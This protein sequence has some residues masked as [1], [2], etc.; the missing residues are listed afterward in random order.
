MLSKMVILVQKS[1]IYS[2]TFVLTLWLTWWSGVLNPS[3]LPWFLRH[4]PTAPINEL[5]NFDPISSA[6]YSNH[7][8][9]ALLF[10]KMPDGFFL[11]KFN[12]DPRAL[13]IARLEKYNPTWKPSKAD[14][15]DSSKMNVYHSQ[16]ALLANAYAWLALVAQLPRDATFSILKAGAAFLATLALLPLFQLIRNIWGGLAAFI[17]W[18][19]LLLSIG[20][21]LFATSLY[22]SIYLSILPTTVVAIVAQRILLSKCNLSTYLYTALALYLVTTFKFLVGLEFI[23][24]IML[25]PFA[26]LAMIVFFSP[27][28]TKMTLRIAIIAALAMGLGVITSLII[29]DFLHHHAFKE[30]GLEY[31]LSR[32][33]AWKTGAEIDGPRSRNPMRLLVPLWIGVR[34]WGVPMLVPFLCGFTALLFAPYIFFKSNYSQ[35]HKGMA[36]AS[37]V[38]LA[39]SMSWVILQ[40]EHIV[41]HPAYATFWIALPLSCFCLPATVMFCISTIKT[42]KLAVH[43]RDVKNSDI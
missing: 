23:T 7:I 32:A 42:K 2:L 3:V 11:M 14:F 40:Y 35:Q 18:G 20:C 25:L 29:F 5:S 27:T 12:Q 43:S 10:Q 31:L 28:I 38:A 15:Q 33:S 9:Y 30:S 24:I 21:N 36:A 41:W 34:H 37:L 22:W 19:F 4:Y 16:T 26:P 8:D 13:N 39:A 6:L 1:R 17:L